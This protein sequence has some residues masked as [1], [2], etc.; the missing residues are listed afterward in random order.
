MNHKVTVGAGER[1]ANMQVAASGAPI[2]SE[3]GPYPEG[4]QL[5]AGDSRSAITG[6]GNERRF[7]PTPTVC[8]AALTNRR[9][10]FHG[11]W[12]TIDDVCIESRIP[13]LTPA[14]AAPTL[15]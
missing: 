12:Q 2:A 6:Q 1:P 11:N 8:G 14:L 7:S 4:V 10:S 15:R 5:L 3:H 13:S 9:P